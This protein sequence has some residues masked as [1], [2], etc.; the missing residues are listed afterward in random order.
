ME[1]LEKVL[2]WVG[3]AYGDDDLRMRSSA[4][5]ASPPTTRSVEDP[6]KLNPEEAT[7]GV[8][9]VGPGDAGCAP[10]LT[11]PAIPVPRLRRLVPSPSHAAVVDV[12][13]ASTGVEL[14]A[15]VVEA[16]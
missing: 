10:P 14:A 3:F 13:P 6:P 15:G 12:E 16:A 11:A 4:T 1:K 8:T 5:T 2:H 7:G 9:G